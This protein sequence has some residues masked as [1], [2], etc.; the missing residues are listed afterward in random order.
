MYGFRLPKTSLEYEKLISMYIF[1]FFVHFV[2]IK[3]LL[4][5][6][7]LELDNYMQR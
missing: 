3:T 1:V 4:E 6:I 5:I 2:T 7:I